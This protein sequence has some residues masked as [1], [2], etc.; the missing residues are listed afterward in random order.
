LAFITDS[1]GSLPEYAKP[2][3]VHENAK[4]SPYY[5]ASVVAVSDEK[6]PLP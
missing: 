6:I 4:K 1:K 5:L 3:P 2:Y